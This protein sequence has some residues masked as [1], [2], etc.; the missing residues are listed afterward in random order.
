MTLLLAGR[1][2]LAM[3]NEQIA[4][5]SALSM[6]VNSAAQNVT[7]LARLA[8]HPAAQGAG[9]GRLLLTD[10]IDYARAN[11]AESIALNTQSSNYRSL[12]LYRAVGFR[13][14]GKMIPVLAHAAV[15]VE[16]QDNS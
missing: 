14:I 5:Y 11:L 16:M 8:V 1:V 3:R 2:Q 13:N 7:Q 15:N 10:V 4:G 6:Q 12:A 9:I